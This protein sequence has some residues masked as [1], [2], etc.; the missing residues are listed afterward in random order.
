MHVTEVWLCSN[1]MSFALLLGI[2]GPEFSFTIVSFLLDGMMLLR[3]S[4]DIPWTCLSMSNEN[5]Q[6]TIGYHI[7]NA[8]LQ[9]FVSDV[10]TRVLLIEAGS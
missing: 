3:A 1:G 10:P 4:G 2:F 5:Y 6:A 7:E 9:E 8:G